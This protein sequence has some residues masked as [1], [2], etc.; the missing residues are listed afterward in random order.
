MRCTRRHRLCV[1]QIS[2]AL[3]ESLPSR[4]AI[5]LFK[6]SSLIIVEVGGASVV[7]RDYIDVTLQIAGVEM[8]H[9]LLLVTNLLLLI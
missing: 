3:Y 1:C 4:P 9:L 6:N 5:N 2:S 8:A 7:V